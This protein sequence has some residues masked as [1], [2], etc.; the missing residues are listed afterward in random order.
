MID[1]EAA[2]RVGQRF[3]DASDD[4]IKD[5]VAIGFWLKMIEQ[6]PDHKSIMAEWDNFCL[7]IS[8]L[9]LR[10]VF[11]QTGNENWS[12]HEV[13]KLINELR[14]TTS[15]QAWLK[16]IGE[17][18][19]IADTYQKHLDV[20]LDK[21]PTDDRPL[22]TI[23]TEISKFLK[24]CNA[25]MPKE[26]VSLVPW[27]RYL[28]SE[29]QDKNWELFEGIEDTP[30]YLSLKEFLM[31]NDLIQAAIDNPAGFYQQLKDLEKD[32]ND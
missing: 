24:I 10:E 23:I 20:L 28:A 16:F 30:R 4:Y 26:S 14:G 12:W 15:I 22:E 5:Q 3:F 13:M 8:S 7:L 27:V 25:K 1:R 2:E 29:P 31:K 32:K 17:Q 21:V 19:V 9:D 11:P 18:F 6:L